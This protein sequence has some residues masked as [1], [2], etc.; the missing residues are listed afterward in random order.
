M[1]VIARAE[2]QERCGAMLLVRQHEL[3]GGAVVHGERPARSWVDQLG[4]DVAARAEVHSVLLL[5]L[6][7]ERDPDVADAHRLGDPCAPALLELRSEGRLA[8]A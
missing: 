8:A 3:A 1:H 5:A 6:S 2:T 4:V 7:P